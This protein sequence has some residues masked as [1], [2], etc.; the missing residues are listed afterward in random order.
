MPDVDAACLFWLDGVEHLGFRRGITHGPP[1]LVLL[2]LIF[3]W[4][5]NQALDG[6]AL[7]TALFALPSFWRV[8]GPRRAWRWAALVLVSASIISVPWWGARLVPPLSLSLEHRAVSVNFNRERRQPLVTGE[9]F[10]REELDEGLYAYTAIRAPLGLG[11]PVYH[12]W[13]HGR[14]L[15]DSVRADEMLAEVIGENFADKLVYYPTTTREESPKMGR[16]TDLMRSG[17]A[18]ADLG[19]APLTPETDRAMICGNLA[20]NLEL[21]AML[22]EY[23][24]EEGANS[25]PKHYVVEKAF[26]G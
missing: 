22:E 17:E 2:P 11:Q 16:I 12:Y 25:D 7:L 4:P 10:S 9:T 24:L 19:V 3:K 21:K 6:A 14:E 15:V 18:F 23:G 8:G 20:F 1:A 26:V 13:F 5:T